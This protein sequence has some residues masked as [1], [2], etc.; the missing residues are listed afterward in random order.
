MPRPSRPLRKLS[1]LTGLR[2]ARH[3]SEQVEEA[4][5]DPHRLARFYLEKQAHVDR[6]RLAFFREHFWR[7]NG[8]KWALRPD[9]EF[10]GELACH[11]KRQLDSDFALSVAMPMKQGKERPKVSKVTTPLV[12]NVMLAAFRRSVVAAGH[13]TAVLARW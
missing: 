3:A 5:N 7:W 2:K 4:A 10:R 12:S 1:R 13:G 6:P 11:C 9:A 8:K